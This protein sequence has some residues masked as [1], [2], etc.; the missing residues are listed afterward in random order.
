MASTETYELYDKILIFF[1]S[2]NC[3]VKTKVLL[4]CLKLP[5]SPP[6]EYILSFD[7]FS[8]TERYIGLNGRKS[9]KD[10]S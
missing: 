9:R 8:S 5:L 4:I 2:V 1:V 3:F 6:G 10:L 7:R